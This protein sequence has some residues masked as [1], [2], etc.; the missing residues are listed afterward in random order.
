[1]SLDTAMKIAISGLSASQTALSN[2][3]NNIANVNTPGY[4]RKVVQFENQTAGT[5]AAGVKISG[6]TRTVDLFLAREQL[7]AL[8][9]ARRFQ[10]AAIIHDRLQ[11]LLGSPGDNVSLTGKLDDLLNNI[12]AL[13]T[14]PASGVRRTALVNSMDTFAAEINRV[15]KLTQEL[16]GEAD[17]RISE[18]LGRV[19]NAI[20]RIHS[21]NPAIARE[22]VV[23]RDAT[24]L[25]DQRES[26]LREIAKIVDVRVNTMTGGIMGVSTTSGVVLLDQV[27]RK[28]T[29]TPPGV[30]NT[31]VRFSQIIVNKV[32]PVSQV[33][34][35]T[36]AVIDPNVRSGELRGLLDVRSQ[37]LPEI[38]SSLGEFAGQVVDALNAA[39]NS[40]STVPAASTLTGRNVGVLAT[41]LHASF[42]GKVTLATLSATNNYVN[43]VEID[44]DANTISKNGAAAVAISG[45]TIA[46]VI[47]DVN[48]ALGAGTLV[49]SNG[50]LTFAA[51]TGASGVAALQ[52]A[53]TPSARGGRGFSHFFGLNDIMSSQVPSHFD[54]GFAATDAH[55]YGNSG[56]MSL[57]LTGPNGQTAKTFSL[58]FASIGGANF[59]NVVTDLNTGLNGFG[60]FALDS[61][62]AMSFTPTASYKDYKLAVTSD[63]T[64]RGASTKSLSDQ[65]GIGDRYVQDAAFG[66]KVRSDILSDPKKL[67][68][69]KLD[70]S[71][72]ALAGT[73]PGLTSGDNRGVIDF[74]NVSTNLYSFAAAGSLA[75]TKTT[76]STFGATVLSDL[77]SKAEQSALRGKDSAA[78]AA[79]LEARISAD[80]GVN[81]DEELAN[82]ILFQN[83]YSASARM[84]RTARDLFDIL[85][86]LSA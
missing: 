72:N 5:E 45:T 26:A 38:A 46:D 43:R 2:T 77:A 86:Q 28:L 33:L 36:G 78:L 44:F 68:L 11:S 25:I 80:S 69:A 23:G 63:T 59:S 10:A 79:E 30:I 40:N 22:E 7:V 83:A 32:D 56:I 21:L 61:N 74:Q 39:H 53:T 51:P 9:Q 48:T 20:L 35:P 62:G 18:A 85:L 19:N 55:G 13:T 76:L 42:T 58:D 1:M 27:P 17:R 8:A 71:A 15:S 50:A 6:V 4:A 47:S 67:A 66:V 54:T 81:L 16:R 3:A 65:F 73:V 84:I 64:S 41:D 24:A 60:S 29:Y 82:M 70:L 49:L 52:D 57:V 31:Q 14:D 37:E 12:P 34:T 75:A